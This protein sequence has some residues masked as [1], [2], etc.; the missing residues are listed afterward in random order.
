M[1]KRI[2]LVLSFLF[3]SVSL[4]SCSLFDTESSNT[5]ASDATVVQVTSTV[6]S[7]VESVDN[8]CIGILATNQGSSVGSSGSGI[9]YKQD[10]NKYYAITNYHVVEDCSIVR[11]YINGSVYITATLEA[12]Y[13][14]HDLAC[15][16]FEAASKYGVEAVDI[17]SSLPVVTPG[18]TVIAVGCPLGLDNFNY[19]TVGVASTSVFTSTITSD[20]KSYSVSIFYH[21]AAINS[22][23]SG[24]ALF[25]MNGNLLG[26]NFRKM[27]SD[28]EGNVVEGMGQSIYV[29]EVLNFIEDY[30]LM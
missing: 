26:I 2:C 15:I 21:D 27:V 20:N 11:A 28:S 23:N 30:N 29:E 7:V 17:T 1:K 13:P 6:S 18:Q 10:G 9:V 24:G 19:V 14:G 8:A 4:S 5:L 3:V 12:T 22:G 16:S 25:D